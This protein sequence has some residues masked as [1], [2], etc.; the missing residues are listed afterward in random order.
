MADLS[1]AVLVAILGVSADRAAKWTDQLN[2]AMACFDVDTPL[3]QAGFLAQVG[4]E[5][6]SLSTV[7]ENLNYSALALQ[8]VFGKYFTAD[9]AADYARQPER[10]ANRVY[11]GR[12]GNGDEAS[13]DGW[14]FRGRGLIQVTGR[15]NYQ[16]CGSALH[17]AF[18][19]YGVDLLAAPE[20]LELPADAA[21]SAAWFWSANGL[22][23]LADAGDIV[24]MTKRINGRTNGLEDRRKL[25]AAATSALIG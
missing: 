20:T 3:R 2:Q 14:R 21:L 11:A 22:N 16:R 4:H 5:S 15:S 24:A 1:S 6:G 23:E 10:I 19:G 25:Y 13:G 8:Q 7:V 18:D 12:M 9:S 17:Q